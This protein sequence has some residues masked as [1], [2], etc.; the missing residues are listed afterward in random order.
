[1]VGPVDSLDHASRLVNF[2]DRIWGWTLH[3]NGRAKGLNCGRRRG[4]SEDLVNWR[5][6]TV[7][8]AQ[9]VERRIVVPVA[10]GSN[11]STHPKRREDKH[12]FFAVSQ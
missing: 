2:L 8:V 4:C 12:V 7:G 3:A 5:N 10:E 6:T 1:V 9:L 11:P